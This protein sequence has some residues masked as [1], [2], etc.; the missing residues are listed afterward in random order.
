MQILN[1]LIKIELNILKIVLCIVNNCIC[2]LYI[3]GNGKFQVPTNN[4]QNT[5]NINKQKKRVS[6]YRPDEH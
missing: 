3:I 4:Y 2:T 1:I 5:L 6:G